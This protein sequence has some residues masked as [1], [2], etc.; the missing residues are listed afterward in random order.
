MITCPYCGAANKQEDGTFCC[1]AFT[2]SVSA[3]LDRKDLE[4][5]QRHLDAVAEKASRN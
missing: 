3:V 5:R 2:V 1:S 4:D